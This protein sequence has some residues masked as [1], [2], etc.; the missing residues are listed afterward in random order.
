MPGVHAT[1]RLRWGHPFVDGRLPAC[2]DP[3]GTWSGQEGNQALRD[4]HRPGPGP[5]PAVWGGEGLVQVHVDD[6]EPHVARA[7]HAEDG[8]EVGSV[9]V[10]EA[11]DLM[12]GGGN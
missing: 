5:S 2:L 6:V 10:E 7:H 11:P 4:R 9:V 8:I 12:H 3:G 1:D